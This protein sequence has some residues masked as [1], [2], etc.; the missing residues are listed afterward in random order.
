MIK[1]NI[2]WTILVTDKYQESLSFYKDKLGFVIEREVPEEEFCQFKLGNSNLAI[3]GRQQLEKLVG[4]KFSSAPS[5][6]YSFPESENIDADVADLKQ[7]GV[8]FLNESETQPWGQRTA[9]FADPDGH[10][11]ELQ[12]WVKKL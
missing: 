2:E 7:K 4:V 6:I 3:Y 8:V 1:P 10:I 11:W 12:Q 5:A 9:Y